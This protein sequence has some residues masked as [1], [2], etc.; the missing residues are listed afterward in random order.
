MI[1]IWPKITLNRLY[2]L[3]FLIQK[4]NHYLHLNIR[5][6]NCRILNVVMFKCLNVLLCYD[7]KLIRRFKVFTYMFRRPSRF[8]YAVLKVWCKCHFAFIYRSF[9][10]NCFPIK[11]QLST[12]SVVDTSIFNCWFC[13]LAF[14]KE[15]QL[16]KKKLLL[17]WWFWR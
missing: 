4:S 16:L 13:N 1:L 8:P 3:C 7:K 10:S 15:N 6:W 17:L 11:F 14:K 5:L 9:L 2:S 12:H